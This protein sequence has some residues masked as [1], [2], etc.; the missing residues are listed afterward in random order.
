[1]KENEHYRQ[2]RRAAIAILNYL[3]DHATAKD[4]VSGIA[5]FWVVENEEIVAEALTLLMKEGVIEKIGK[6]F[7][8]APSRTELDNSDL[9]EKIL[10]NL[11]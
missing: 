7:Q 3:R 2:V 1:M 4:T 11:N 9:F 8:L 10:K 5:K 6:I